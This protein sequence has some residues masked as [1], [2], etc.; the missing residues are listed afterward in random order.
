MTA[1]GPDE[2]GDRP[3][4]QRETGEV[5]NTGDGRQLRPG[6]V[7]AA[8]VG[9]ARPVSLLGLRMPGEDDDREATVSRRPGRS[10]IGTRAPAPLATPARPGQPRPGQPR[11]GQPRPD[12]PRPDQPRPDQPRP[13]QPRLLVPA[14]ALAGWTPDV[15]LFLPAVDIA[16]VDIPAA[17]PV[18]A[19]SPETLSPELTWPDVALPEAGEIPE[20]V[21]ADGSTGADPATAMV[22]CLRVHVGGFSGGAGRMAAAGLGMALAASRRDRVIAVDVCAEQAGRAQDV[23]AVWYEV[24][25]VDGP[26]GWDQPLPAAASSRADTVVVATRADLVDLSAADDV[27][28]TLA[29]PDVAGTAWSGADGS[30]VV[31]VVETVPIRWSA[32]ARRRLARLSDRAGAVVVVPFDPALVDGVPFTWSGLRRRTRA[33]FGELAAAVDAASGWQPPVDRLP[34]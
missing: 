6:A 26:P 25:L 15:G 33:A 3:G 29:G 19:G 23:L 34:A 14:P 17:D 10:R 2:N 24:V 5:Q 13:D 32:R 11:P 12:Q 20:T 8:D 4:A 21:A 27:L 9:D 18:P 7:F 31:A 16:A 22:N 30:L 28:V 1:R